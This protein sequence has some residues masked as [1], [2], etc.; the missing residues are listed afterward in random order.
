[1]E[2]KFLDQLCWFAEDCLNKHCR[3][4]HPNRLRI[5]PDQRLTQ[6]YGLQE[7]H[8]NFFMEF[9]LHFIWAQ[10]HQFL[11]VTES[12]FLKS[13]PQQSVSQ[14]QPIH[15][16]FQN[17]F[18][19][20]QNMQPHVDN[21]ASLGV[22]VSS[23]DSDSICEPGVANTSPTVTLSPL[24]AGAKSKDNCGSMPWSP[25]IESLPSYVAP[26]KCKW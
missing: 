7:A 24:L 6:F 5:Q 19:L 14:Q 25:S 12:P 17:M 3:F 13:F 8:R 26:L 20:F 15:Q 1:M 18:Q 10:H 22:R 16:Q 21:D 23:D 9:C 11:Q 4:K 2:S